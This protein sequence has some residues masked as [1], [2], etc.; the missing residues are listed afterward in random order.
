MILAVSVIV[1]NVFFV[2]LV[3]VRE[4]SKS[5]I[6]FKISVCCVFVG[7]AFLYA[8]NFVGERFAT[9]LD[10]NYF[11]TSTASLLGIPGIVMMFMTR[12]VEMLFI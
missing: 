2:M 1:L 7:T 4:I 8:M 5:K 12:F 11:T 3:V 9:T 6:P 10:T